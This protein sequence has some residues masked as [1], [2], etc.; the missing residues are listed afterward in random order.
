MIP[1]FACAE[2]RPPDLEMLRAVIE[3]ASVEQLAEL[4]LER[5]QTARAA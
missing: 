2:G 1:C 4:G 3:E 5:M